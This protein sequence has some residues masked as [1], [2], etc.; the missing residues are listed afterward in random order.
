MR[1]RLRE[2]RHYWW[3]TDSDVGNS[4]VATLKKKGYFAPWGT[5]FATF[6]DVRQTIRS[7]KILFIG[8]GEVQKVYIEL[9]NLFQ[10]KIVNISISNTRENPRLLNYYLKKA[11]TESINSNISSVYFGTQVVRDALYGSCLDFFFGDIGISTLTH[12]LNYTQIE[13]FQ[14]FLSTFDIIV[15]NVFGDKQRKFLSSYE[16]YPPLLQTFFQKIP[17]DIKQKIIWIG[18]HSMPHYYHYTDNIIQKIRHIVTFEAKVPYINY[19]YLFKH[20]DWKNCTN[21]DNHPSQMVSRILGL[22]V[23]ETINNMNSSIQRS[24]NSRYNI[25]H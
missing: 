15:T 19:Y 4:L 11:F 22:R 20:C 14:N 6:D 24:D 12:L 8:D 10:G 17:N 7:H 3:V 5:P 2:G 9:I 21:E 18:P 16:E 23:L 13:C 1:N 25:F